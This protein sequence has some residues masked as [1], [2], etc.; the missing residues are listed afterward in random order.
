MKKWEDYIFT[1]QTMWTNRFSEKIVFSYLWSS[2]SGDVANL[3]AA[4]MQSTCFS[5]RLRNCHFAADGW[6]AFVDIH[7]LQVNNYSN[8]QIN[9]MSVVI[10]VVANLESVSL[11][12]FK[13]FVALAKTLLFCS[14][15]P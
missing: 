9:L 11:P 13:D 2:T 7:I 6:I 3:S 12:V 4:L 15:S 14:F 8:V 5:N 10:K 1:L